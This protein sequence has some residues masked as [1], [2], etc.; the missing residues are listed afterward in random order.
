MMAGGRDDPAMFD[1]SMSCDTV[2][3]AAVRS[4]ATHTVRRGGFRWLK[5][6]SV[7]V[8]SWRRSDVVECL[9]LKPC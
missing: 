6:V 7:S 8:V 5:P 1:I 4:M 2:S 9:D 3:K